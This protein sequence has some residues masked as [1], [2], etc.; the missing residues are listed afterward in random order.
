MALDRAR[1]IIPLGQGL[2]TDVDPKLLPV[3]KVTQMENLLW[4]PAA[5]DGAATKRPGYVAMPG[6]YIT[7]GTPAP[8]PAPWQFTQHKGSVVALGVAGPRPVAQFSPGAQKWLVP[9][10]SSTDGANGIASKLRGQVLATRST[11]ERSDT[12]TGSGVTQNSGV[13]VASDGTL[14]LEAWVHLIPGGSQQQIAAKFIEVAT[15]KVLFTYALGTITGNLGAPM[16]VYTNGIFTLLWFDNN[17]SS[18]KEVHWTAAI[19]LS[20]TAAAS[21]ITT[22]ATGVI[23]VTTSNIDAVAQGNNVALI[24]GAT[25]APSGKTMQTVYAAGTPGSVTTNEILTSVQS[26]IPAGTVG[27]VTDLGGVGQHDFVIANS[28]GLQYFL[29]VNSSGATTSS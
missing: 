26:R 1:V 5:G 19:V 12:T 10:V 25:A 8:L 7:S 9:P 29:N 15:K 20:G 21:S 28:G 2:A 16:C 3:G 23:G 18:I 24:Y 4:T 11:V 17:A 14:V 6:N 22:V 13:N 27:W